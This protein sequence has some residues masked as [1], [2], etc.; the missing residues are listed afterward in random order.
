MFKWLVKV[1][2]RFP[3]RRRPS[4]RDWESRTQKAC[5][6][7]SAAKTMLGWQPEEDRARFIQKGIDAAL[8]EYRK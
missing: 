4:Y 2:V 6:D 5:F 3:E 7:A 8:A 1:A